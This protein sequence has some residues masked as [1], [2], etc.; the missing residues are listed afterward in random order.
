MAKVV[1]L[2]TKGVSFNVADEGQRE[3][4]EHCVGKSNF[5]GYVKSLILRDMLGAPAPVERWEPA[6]EETDINSFI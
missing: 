3:L 4:Y 2:K 1:R 6:E 5:S